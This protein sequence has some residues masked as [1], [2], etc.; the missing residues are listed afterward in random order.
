[1]K[2][3]IRNQ[4]K[5][6]AFFF[7]FFLGGE[8]AVGEGGMGEWGSG[9][10]GRGSGGRGRGEWG[11]GMEWKWNPPCKIINHHAYTSRYSEP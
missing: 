1:M 6:L 10:R 7:Y 9:G 2:Y 8:G 4:L 3:L 5:L 11:K